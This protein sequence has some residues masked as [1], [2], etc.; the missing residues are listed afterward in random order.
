MQK[1]ST[2]F[3]LCHFPFFFIFYYYFFFL[4]V[5][6]LDMAQRIS[7]DLTFRRDT[8]LVALTKEQYMACKPPFLVSSVILFV[9]LP[10]FGNT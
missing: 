6:N 10:A 2:S 1:K 3:F 8:T 5:N 7:I 9:A 4:F